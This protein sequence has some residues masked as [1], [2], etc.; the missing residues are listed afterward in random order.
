MI[1]PKRN[2][3]APHNAYA[4]SDERV[5]IAKDKTAIVSLSERE[6]LKPG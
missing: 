3:V 5:A 4:D 1:R 6:L 2:A